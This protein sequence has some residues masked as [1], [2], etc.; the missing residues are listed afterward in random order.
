MSKKLNPPE[1]YDDN[2]EWTD[3]TTERATLASEVHGPDVMSVLVKRGRPAGSNKERIAIR[4][5]HDAL[6]KLRALGPGWQTR[7]N[8]VL[9]KAAEG[10]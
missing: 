2:P 10:L 1:V 6:A 4:V 9:V 5:N 7:I 3:Q 8:E